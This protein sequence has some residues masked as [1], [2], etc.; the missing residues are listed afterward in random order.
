MKV[1]MVERHGWGREFT[2]VRAATEQDALR[3]ARCLPPYEGMVSISV[4]EVVHEG[5]EDVLWSSYE[6]GPD[7]PRD[8]D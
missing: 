1:W 3:V 4:T 7:T 5:G 8:A 6:D 2:L